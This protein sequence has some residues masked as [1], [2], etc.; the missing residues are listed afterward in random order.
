[1]F[2]STTVPTY[3]RAVV[4]V[5]ISSAPLTKLRTMCLVISV[6]VWMEDNK[7]LVNPFVAW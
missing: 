7:M 5:E 3:L 2:Y 6:G 1:M 4:V